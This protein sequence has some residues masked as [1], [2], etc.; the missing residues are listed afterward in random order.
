[1]VTR[2]EIQ[3]D[4]PDRKRL[5]LEGLDPSPVRAHGEAEHQDCVPSGPDPNDKF[6]VNARNISLSFAAAAESALLGVVSVGNLMAELSRDTDTRPSNT[7]M[8]DLPNRLRTDVAVV[9][10]TGDD[11]KKE[12]PDHGSV[13]TGVRT[14]MKPEHKKKRKRKPRS[15]R[16]TAQRPLS[17]KI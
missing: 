4:H 17:G 6:D 7:A 9:A 10:E 3:K 11:G 16:K 12:P 13:T 1:M 8:A 15:E 14:T 2:R 5:P